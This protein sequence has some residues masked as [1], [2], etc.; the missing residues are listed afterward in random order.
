MV[1]RT[2]KIGVS[3]LITYFVLYLSSILFDFLPKWDAYGHRLIQGLPLQGYLFVDP[4]FWGIPLIGFSFMWLG[5]EWY[6]HHFK[7]DFILSIPFAL[8]FVVGSYVAWYLAMVGF[9]WN[10]AFLSALSQGNP[11]P[12]LASLPV[13]LDFVTGNF[14]EFIIQSPF[15][16]FILA[17][18]LSW[19][20]FVLIHRYWGETLPH[21]AHA[22]TP[23][24]A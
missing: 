15:F 18:V 19:V 1:T 3:L 5:L 24:T 6:V 23:H 4:L 12:T 22:H 8:V 21:H 17:G 2:Q 7:D 9:Y 13:V 16:L 10:N 14:F 20:S 11:S